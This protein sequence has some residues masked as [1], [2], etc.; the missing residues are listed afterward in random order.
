MLGD[1]DLVTLSYVELFPHLKRCLAV[2]VSYLQGD[3]L[4]RMG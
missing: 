1:Q 3:G 4:T 2:V